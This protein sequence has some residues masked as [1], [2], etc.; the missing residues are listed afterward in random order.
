MFSLQKLILPNDKL[1]CALP[2]SEDRAAGCGVSST[3]MFGFLH[4]C[5]PKLETAHLDLRFLKPS[6]VECVLTHL[7]GILRVCDQ[8]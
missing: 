2:Q 3:C 7:R 1:C 5:K 8:G 4:I 6:L